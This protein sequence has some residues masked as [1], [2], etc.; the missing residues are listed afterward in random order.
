MKTILDDFRRR[1]PRRTP[2]Q[3]FGWRIECLRRVCAR[4]KRRV[5]WN[6]D[7]TPTT[8][9]D[10]ALSFVNPLPVATAGPTLVRT[11]LHQQLAGWSVYQQRVSTSCGGS[12]NTRAPTEW[13]TS[14]PG[15][16]SQT[17]QLVATSLGL[18]TWLTG[19]LKDDQVEA[20]LRLLESNAEQPLFFVGCG[21]S[22]GQVMCKELKALLNPKRQATMTHQ[23]LEQVAEFPQVGPIFTLGDWN[24]RASVRTSG[25]TYTI[26]I[27]A[28]D[29]SANCSTGTGYRRVFCPISIT[30]VSRL[31][32]PAVVHR[33]TANHLVYFLDYTT[34]LG[35][36]HRQSRGGNHRPRR[37]RRPL[38]RCA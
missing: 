38:S 25:N 16:I 35:T 20:L 4:A 12:T 6:P 36:P 32:A 18:G 33:L 8:Q 37:T 3:P 7:F 24:N 2:Q 23:P 11:T 19:A 34:L 27:T 26:A 14:R 1:R 15:H 21:R 30:R 22:D 31:P 17:F 10:H 28:G 13:P 29:W 5:A 9:A